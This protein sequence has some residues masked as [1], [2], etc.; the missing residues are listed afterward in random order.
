MTK[1]PYSKPVLT[2]KQTLSAVTSAP[3][4]SKKV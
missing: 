4:D 3:I 2:K 1:K